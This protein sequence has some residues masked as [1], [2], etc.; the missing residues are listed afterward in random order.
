MEKKKVLKYKPLLPFEQPSNVRISTISAIASLEA[1]VDQQQMYDTLPLIDKEDPTAVGVFELKHYEKNPET[2]VIVQKHRWGTSGAD[3]EVLKIVKQYFQN[4]LTIVWRFLSETGEIKITNGFIF[5]TGNVKAVGLKSDVDVHRCYESLRQYLQ[6]HAD[7]I[8]LK[9][10]NDQLQ[11]VNPRPTMFNTD[12][13]ARNKL[14]R[15]R[16][17]RLIIEEYKLEDS[18]FEIDIYPA[19]K[20]KFAWNE[21]YMHG[22][23]AAQYTP[24]VCYCS[25]K[26][27]GKGRGNGNG[28]CKIV[29]I[30][31]F[32][33]DTKANKKPGKII[34]TGANQFRQVKDVHQFMCEL[35]KTHHETLFYHEPYMETIMVPKKEDSDKKPSFENTSN[36]KQSVPH[37]V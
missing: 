10:T 5:R 4:Q 20:I 21:E 28:D 35:L 32:G 17:F 6:I 27:N 33:N 31:V 37:T 16:M 7:K 25:N 26:C 9:T 23:M 30:C 24:G 34:I 15:E 29:T 1:S 13:V 12:F 22:P 14:L 8:G 19:V 11:L 3:V 18:E 36:A 2:G